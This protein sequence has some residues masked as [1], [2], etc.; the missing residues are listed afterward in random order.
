MPQKPPTKNTHLISWIEEIARLCGAEAVQWCDGSEA[1]RKRLTELAVEC[2][3]VEALDPQ[4]L[5]G[6]LYGRSAAHDVA[7]VEHLTYICTRDKKDAGPT[8]HWMD[9]REAYEK[10]GGILKGSMRGRTLYVVPFVMGIP[11]SSFNK[12]GVELTDSVYVVLNMRIMARMGSVALKELGDSPNFTRGVHSKADLDP[13]RRMICHFPEDNTIWSVGSNYG[14]NVLL[15]KKC[16]ALRIASWLGRKEGWLAEHMMIVGIENPEGEI[17]YV[18]GA[19]PSQCGKTNLAMLTPPPSMAG[20]RVWTVGDDIAW[21]RVGDDGRL[22]AVNPEAGFFGVAPGTNSKTNPNAM[23][24]IRRNTIFT[25]VLK[26]PDGTVWW[27]GMD[28]EPPTEGIDWLGKKWTPDSGTKGAHPNSRF[29]APAS[30]CPSISP[31]WE[32]PQGVPISAIVFGGRRATT[33]PLVYQSFN[34]RHGVY[35][36]ATMSSET[37]SAATGKVGVVRRDPM[38]M[39]PFCGYHV[40]DYFGHWLAMGKKIKHPPLI[41]HVNWFRMD[42]HGKFL[43]PGFG[44]N[45][46]VLRWVIER[47]KGTAGAV[48][49]AI[50]Y[51]PAARSIDLGGTGVSEETLERELL[52]VDKKEW[53]DEVISQSEFLRSVGEAL[54]AEILE[55]HHALLRRLEGGK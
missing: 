33:E 19:F 30:Q 3:E 7:R 40:G 12:I 27:E 38:A 10:A 50:G 36:G 23:A 22:W 8:N 31:E 5:P 16:L 45:L 46:R 47:A 44:E 53:V 54:P 20:Y 25:N 21:L 17:A 9:P 15:G 2:G 4:K 48:E 39:L 51:L 11:G 14:G 43:W 26:R 18:A 41:F 29:T 34:W 52:R 37:T 24:T 13:A 55:E 28:G 1:E 49:S 35:L 42:S 32:N 6:C